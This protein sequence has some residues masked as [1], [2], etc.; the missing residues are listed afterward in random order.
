MIFL[1]KRVYLVE[2]I[3]DAVEFLWVKINLIELSANLVGDILEV[4]VVSI[5]TACQF[6]S[7]GHHILNGV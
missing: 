1:L 4:D 6:A 5:H 3:V 2:P 7:L